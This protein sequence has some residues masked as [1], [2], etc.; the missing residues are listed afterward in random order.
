MVPRVTWAVASIIVLTMIISGPLVPA[1]DF[2]EKPEEESSP[3]CEASGDATVHVV[4]PPNDELKLTRLRFG[5]D[6]YQLPGA[7][8]TV[9]VSEVDGCPVLAY[10]FVVEELDHSSRRLFWVNQRQSDEM[11]LDAVKV[12]VSPEAV[13][14]APLEATVTISLLADTERT[15]LQKNVTLRADG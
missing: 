5:A 2:T 10:E 9:Q 14:E 6:L 1:V 13:S 11:I 15:I 3:F 7:E 12:S 8:T 4:D